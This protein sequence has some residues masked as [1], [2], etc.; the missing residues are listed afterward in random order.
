MCKK[1]AG[2]YPRMVGD[3]RA[4]HRVTNAE[5]KRRKGQR[6]AAKDAGVARERL[7]ALQKKASRQTRELQREIHRAQREAG[8]P[9]TVEMVHYLRTSG[10]REGKRLPQEVKPPRYEP[11]ATA[12]CADDSDYARHRVPA[13]HQAETWP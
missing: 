10:H 11:I 2:E 3:E 1:I 12:P 6:Q 7:E 5:V 4:R 8:G 9:D 13:S